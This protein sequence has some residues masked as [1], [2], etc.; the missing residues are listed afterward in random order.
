MPSLD[1][2]FELF[3][4]KFRPLTIILAF[5]L[6]ESF[7]GLIPPDFFILWAKQFNSPYAMVG[8]LSA[9]SYCGGVISYVIGYYIGEI[10]KV[11]AWMQKRLMKHIDKLR[12]WG[13]TLIAFAALFPLPYSPVCIAAGTIRFPLRLFLL[14]GLFRIVR[15]FVYAVVLFSVA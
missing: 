14:L 11:Q 15:F 2:Y 6:S 3:T 10:P 12:K 8:L 13:G 4:V 9:L 1:Y 7:L 5:F